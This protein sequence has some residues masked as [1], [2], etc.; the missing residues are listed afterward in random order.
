V[1]VSYKRGP[2]LQVRSSWEPRFHEPIVHGALRARGEVLW[3]EPALAVTQ[4]R[5]P[6]GLGAALAERFAWGRLFGALRASSIGPPLRLL[7]AIA[8]LF[9][10]PVLGW[11]IARLSRG[12]LPG[13]RLLRA[14]PW[15]AAMLVAW[16]FGESLGTLAGP[17]LEVATIPG[18]KEGHDGQG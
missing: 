14:T 2:L 10:A 5:P 12:R 8:S 16:G 3:L 17:A 7:Y 15:L 11:R 9:I 13:G 6:L 1:N 4:E 18:R